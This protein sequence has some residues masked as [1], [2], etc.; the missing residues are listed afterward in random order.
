MSNLDNIP[1]FESQIEGWY[2]IETIKPDG[3]VEVL[4]D[5]FPNLI[6]NYG[7]DTIGNSGSGANGY[8]THCQVGSSNTTPQFTD[9]ALGSYVGSTSTTTSATVVAQSS[10]PYYFTR[11]NVYRFTLGQIVGTIRE[12][13]MGWNSFGSLFS[14]ALILD[15]SG[16]PTSITLTSTDQLQITYLFRLYPP[17]VDSTGTIDI[18]GT[19]YTWTGRAAAVTTVSTTQSSYNWQMQ[20]TGTG[21]V[22]LYPATNV[23]AW[24]SGIAAITT[25]PYS[26]QSGTGTTALTVTD[27]YVTGSYERSITF[28]FAPTAANFNIGSMT[29]PIGWGCYQFGFSPTI[30]KTSEKEFLIKFKVKWARR[31]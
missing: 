23:Y 30:P 13:G 1:S 4:A 11:T 17:T 27:A 7:L 9:T 2:K 24:T 21:A 15:G 26:S 14:R 5:W 29:V 3:S 28:G 20:A 8:L 10:P 25:T 22:G 16:N 6:T 18:D 12:V 19:T 31:V